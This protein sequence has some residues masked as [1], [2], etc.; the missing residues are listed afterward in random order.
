MHLISEA[1]YL[2][3]STAIIYSLGRYEHARVSQTSSRKRVHGQFIPEWVAIG[4]AAPALFM[5]YHGFRV[6]TGMP[7]ALGMCGFGLLAGLAIGWGH[8]SFRLRSHDSDEIIGSAEPGDMPPEDGN[9]YR[10][11][12]GG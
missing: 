1:I 12:S 8:G 7:G 9:P 11:P 6:F 2:A 5:N 10:P 3:S 4:F